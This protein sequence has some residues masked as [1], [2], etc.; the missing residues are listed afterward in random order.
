MGARGLCTND[1]CSPAESDLWWCAE[2]SVPVQPKPNPTR[3]LLDNLSRDLELE[4]YAERVLGVRNPS[5]G[6]CP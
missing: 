1:D 6:G 2:I 3:D 4:G 5:D